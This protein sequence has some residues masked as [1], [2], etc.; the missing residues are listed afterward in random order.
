M[1]EPSAASAE[2]VDHLRESF[3]ADGDGLRDVAARSAET[4]EVVRG[5][6]GRSILDAE[7]SGVALIAVGGYG[8]SQLF[9]H[10][11]VD[12]LLLVEHPGRT[13]T[14]KEQTSQL[15]A[16]LWDAKLRVSHSVRAPAECARVAPDNA[17]LNISL[18]DTRYLA[19]DQTLYEDLRYRQLPRFYLREQKD[20]LKN[21]LELAQ[22]RHALARETI[23]HL[24][25]DI[26]EGPGGLRDLQLACW[27]SQLT[28]MSAVRLPES[29]EFLPAESRD[30]LQSAKK[31]LFALRCYLHYF[32]KRDL[33]K[34]T[35]DLQETV[36]SE[37]AGRAFRQTQRT[38]EWM[39]DYFR[40]VRV[41][42]RLADRQI[43][44]SA[45]TGQSLFTLFRDR[46]SRLSNGD[47]VV[48]RGRLYLRSSQALATQPELALQLFAFVSRHGIPLAVETERRVEKALPVI[49]EQTRSGGP[50]WPMIADTLSLPFAYEALTAMRETGVL[51]AVFP[52][53][54]LIDCLVIR[55]FYHRYTVDEHTFVAIQILHDLSADGDP[56]SERF[57][58]LLSELEKPKLVY[59]ALLFHDVGKGMPAGAHSQHSVDLATKAMD[60]IQLDQEDRET[61]LFLVRHHL[62][63]SA[64]MTGRDISEPET[65]EQFS[66]VVGTE[67]RLKA[68]TLMTF[69]DVSAVNPKAMTA[70]RKDV[71][72][73]LYISSYR[74]LSRDFQERRI[75]VERSEALLKRTA[76]D[77]EK[78][79]ITEFL[80]GFP[81][82]YLR[83]Q[84]SDQIFSQFQLSRKLAT[85]ASAVS[86]SKRHSLYDVVVVTHDRPFLFASL[87]ATLS[88]QGLNIEKVEAF[89][90]TQGM[91]LDTFVVSD[92][93]RSLELNPPE[94]LTLKNALKKA[95]EGH[96]DISEIVG[97]RQS[98]FAVKR[99]TH[100]KPRVS[101]DNES[102]PSATV[103]HVTAQDRTGLLFDLAS[104]ISQFE[105]SIEV[106]LIDTQGHRAIDVFYLAGPGGEKLEPSKCE[107]LKE[108]L[109]A[110]C[111]S[112]TSS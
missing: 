68:L 44:E 11:D 64:T 81:R 51:F 34:L 83:T 84:P 93:Q 108:E 37:G 60:R 90:N 21:L 25:P 20:L 36:A 42:Y 27:I 31:F 32:N 99:K 55:D 79:E 22:I 1:S 50:F 77:E 74:V 104:K 94:I 10:S 100:V 2:P 48:R 43:E 56:L 62:E 73:Q 65:I 96:A 33:N 54:E 17:E 69:A 88:S 107:A 35:F 86:I 24:E 47:F 12:L 70:W 72:W 110:A 106:V 23:Y 112:S 26:K 7:R 39:R 105:C 80:E 87:C 8:R 46:K 30:K 41:I 67:A 91:A 57:S 14:Y 29:E 82:R 78:A 109:E 16:Q 76:S 6:F 40:H 49:T 5:C 18:L 101:F 13:A 9:P 103:F 3:F 98:A 58:R 38:S 75:H 15:L 89:A 59:F 71:L 45:G 102:S 19:G 63:M 85:S 95:A 111:S 4:D 66:N 61:V 53:Y 28:N 97:R 52:E 92:P